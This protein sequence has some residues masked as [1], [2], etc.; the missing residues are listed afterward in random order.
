MRHAL[1]CT[2]MQRSGTSG[3]DQRTMSP[4]PMARTSS[5]SST[6]NWNMKMTTTLCPR[7]GTT[8]PQ[9]RRTTMSRPRRTQR[10][11]VSCAPGR[12]TKTTAGTL[13]TEPTTMMAPLVMTVRFLQSST[14]DFHAPTSGSVSV[15]VSSR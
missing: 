15:D 2:G 5:S 13:T 9:K 3:P 10:Q 14:V 4:S 12:L 7:K 8:P 1:L 11:G 6:G